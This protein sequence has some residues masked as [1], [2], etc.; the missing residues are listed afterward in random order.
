MRIV[1]SKGQL[2]RKIKK[3]LAEETN[4]RIKKNLPKITKKIKSL[5]PIWIRQQPEVY[6]IL[7]DGVFG[8]LN[9]QFG[10]LPGTSEPAIDAIINA[11]S[12]TVQVE[13]KQDKNSLKGGVIFYIQ[14][15]D[16]YNLLSLPEAVI[17]TL[18]GSL[19]WLY[20]LLIEGNKTIVSGYTYEPDTSGRSGG[21][22][23]KLGQSWRVPSQFAGNQT[24]NFITR[25]LNDRDKELTEILK[26]ALND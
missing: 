5:I 21:G 18:S 22:T 9:A 23:M 12:S 19:P 4:A 13:F 11:I 16:F 2:E 10:F 15:D 26:G 20:W 1:E 14:S 6:S 17:P 24:N 8:S 25:A 7:S 3:A